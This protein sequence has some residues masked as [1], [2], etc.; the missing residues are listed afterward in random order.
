MNPETI[1]QIVRLSLELSLE[2]VKGIP[3]ESRQEWWRQHERNVDF[4]LKLFE[5]LPK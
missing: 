2:I 5:G 4:W 3:V 1:L